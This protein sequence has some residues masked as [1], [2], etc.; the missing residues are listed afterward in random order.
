MNLPYQARTVTPCG[1]DDSPARPTS[2]RLSEHREDRT[3]VLL[4][5]PGAGKTTAFMQEAG[6]S[7]QFEFVTARGLLRGDVDDLPNMSKKVLFIDGL[8]EV[9]VGSSDPRAPLDKVVRKLRKFGPPSF[10][11]S[12]RPADWGLTDASALEP[13]A[14]STY[15]VLRLDPLGGAETHA[16]AARLLR[17]TQVDPT[18]FL[19]QARDNGFTGWLSN[20]QSL[21]LLTNA[22]A[23]GPWPDSR[24]ALFEA[25]C[26]ELARERNREHLDGRPMVLEEDATAAAGELMA[27]TLLSGATA[28]CKHSVE[29]V[30]GD[31]VL[32]E[33]ANGRHAALCHALG[34]KLFSMHSP[35]KFLPMHHHVA[36]YLGARYLASRIEGSGNPGRPGVPANR[37]L[38]LILGEDGGVVSALR[39]LAAWLASLCPEA[40]PALAR[41]DPIGLLS[42][43]DAT[44]ISTTDRSGLIRGLEERSGQLAGDP[45]SSVVL[46]SLVQ[47][48]VLPLLA[49]LIPDRDRGRVRQ[50]I[51]ELLLRGIR[52]TATLRTDPLSI[53]DLIRVVRDATWW[54]R[55]RCTALN[56]AL[57]MATTTADMKCM[58][59]LLY[60][61]KKG[62]VEDSDNELRVRLLI[63]LYPS[64]ISPDRVLDYFPAQANAEAD[65][66]SLVLSSKLEEQS[67]DDDVP[68]LL[69]SLAKAISNNVVM[70]PDYAFD[71]LVTR[72]IWRAL[73]AFGE[74][75]DTSRLLE[76]IERAVEHGCL[77]RRRGCVKASK[78]VHSWFASHPEVGAE[79]LA[80]HRRKHA[81]EQSPA[82]T[83]SELEHAIYGARS[84]WRGSV[85]SREPKLD[86]PSVHETA[87]RWE[88]PQR[89]REERFLAR[90]SREE[91]ERIAYVREHRDSLASAQCQPRLLHEMA[92]VYLG[93]DSDNRPR[94]PFSAL[95][96]SLGDKELAAA[97]LAGL[98]QVHRRTDVPELAE[99]VRLD[100]NG[101]T[102]WLA[103]PLLAGFAEMHRQGEDIG[104]TVEEDVIKSTLACHYLIE[105]PRVRDARTGYYRLPDAPAWYMG[106]LESRRPVVAEALITAC[107]SRIRRSGSCGVHL[108]RLVTDERCRHLARDAVPG[109]L[110]AVPVRCTQHQDLTLYHLLSAAVR[111]TPRRLASWV[112]DK[113]ALRSMNVGQRALWLAAGIAVAPE[114]YLASAAEFI[115]NGSESR[116]RRVVVFLQPDELPPPPTEWPAVHLA[117]AVRALGARIAPWGG[118]ESTAVALPTEIVANKAERLIARWLK[119]LETDPSPGVAEELESLANDKKLD[120]WQEHLVRTRDRQAEVRREAMYRIPTVGQV[121]RV[122]QDA[123]PVS[124]ADLAALLADRLKQLARNI[125]DGN[126][127]DWRQYWNED[128]HRRP[129]KPKHE[130]SCRDALLSDLRALLLRDG[131]DAQPEG[132]YADDKR[133]DIRAAHGGHAVPVE[134]KK[135]T[136]RE[137]WSAINT[138]LLAK[139]VRN[140]ES[141][142]FGIYLVLWFGI[143]CTETVPPSG[144][145]PDTPEELLQQL[146]AQVPPSKKHKIEV[147][148]VDV[149]R[150]RATTKVRR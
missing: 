93:V 136:H 9:R 69:D 97:A 80:C 58:E 54:P 125:R 113:L 81:G 71:R 50:V 100:E 47:R 61:I 63:T 132:H 120:A 121:Q 68:V 23:G 145:L 16:L 106:L 1:T 131:V 129:T 147:V 51:V 26:R 12:C 10:R 102:H 123:E 7:D 44:A 34:T 37:V 117:K 60:D 94:D 143:E 138:Q 62:I 8:D 142:G 135:N 30:P 96:V 73:N 21:A 87:S 98:R 128:H 76:W 140:P 114:R 3:Y 126:T 57:Q 56:A 109:L 103:L 32:S 79:L 85:R 91:W 65:S 95:S 124:A 137:L 92:E 66:A 41:A 42:Y 20:P 28:I 144:R 52:R 82:V 15:P 39:G 13:V 130:D 46:E 127:D 77:G 53:R 88:S 5:D 19:R 101:K 67:D 11:L 48:N 141:G 134:I 116:V 105:P 104:R 17:G 90:R 22:V 108:A 150:R 74:E 6:R 122:L 45:W 64:R 111:C 99:I 2:R 112:G 43:G 149:S 38:A 18:D 75:S 59:E 36:E 139:Y 119:K 35:G 31:L 115:G 27:L 40:R 148:V 84:V 78:K 133:A 118:L 110:D 24:H 4:G 83:T 55:V 72:L 70:M 33:M 86:G 89:D 29:A 49:D 146:E 14:G 107:S 25:A